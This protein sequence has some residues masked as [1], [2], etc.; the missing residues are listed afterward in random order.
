MNAPAQITPD[1]LLALLKS[2]GYRCSTVTHPP[3][4]TVAQSRARRGEI[5]GG[6]CK[7][8]FLKDKKGALWLVV[9]LEDRPVNLKGLKGRIDS[10]HLSFAKPDLLL[11][12][13]GV[14]PGSVTPLALINDSTHRVR[15]VLDKEMLERHDRLNFHPLTNTRTTTIDTSDL[16]DFFHLT[17]HRPRIVSLAFETGEKDGASPAGG[18]AADG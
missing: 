7:N 9:T 1:A 15:L 6:H 10:A 13:L 16:L 8:L 12:A 18:L 17:G 14:A 3:L 4:H 11:D 5:A 2:R